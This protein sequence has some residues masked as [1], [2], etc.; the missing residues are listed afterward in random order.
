MLTTRLSPTTG[1]SLVGAFL[2]HGP[3]LVATDPA[4]NLTT[5]HANINTWRSFSNVLYVEAP[6]NTGFSIGSEPRIKDV[7][8]FA[9]EFVSWFKNWI[10]IFPEAKKMRVFPVGE[11]YA[12]FYTIYGIDK[13]MDAGFDIGGFSTVDAVL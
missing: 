10:E 8:E 3:F 11:S 9:E 5:A 12:S 13:L 2:E 6:V 1:S 7:H 4:T